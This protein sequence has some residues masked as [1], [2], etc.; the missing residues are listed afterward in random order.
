[1]SLKKSFDELKFDVRMRDYNLNNKLIDGNDVSSY[2]SGLPDSKEN[3]V[4]ISIDD[5]STES[6]EEKSFEESVLG[7][8]VANAAQQQTPNPFGND[9]QGGSTGGNY[10]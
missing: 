3:S 8:E 2:L 7:A 4:P 1:M 9:D 5:N 6:T 10:Y